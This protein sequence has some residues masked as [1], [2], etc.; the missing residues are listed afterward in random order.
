MAVAAESTEMS[1]L[2]LA[3]RDW[4]AVDARVWRGF[5]WSALASLR[6]KDASR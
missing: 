1:D 6:L 3:T 5:D 2:A 4:R